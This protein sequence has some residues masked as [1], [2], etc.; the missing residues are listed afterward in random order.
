MAFNDVIPSCIINAMLEEIRKEPKQLHFDEDVFY[1]C[2]SIDI[3]NVISCNEA[4]Q[5]VKATGG[6][7]NGTISRSVDHPAFASL[8]KYLG[9]N[10]Y[11]NIETRWINGDRVMKPFYLNEVFFN[12]G[13]KFVCAAA[14][15]H[16]LKRGTVF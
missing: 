12:V 6:G 1:P 4:W 3:K 16:T 8:R 11:I 15:Q 9:Q 5:V 13:D 14:M 7:R 10:G 2:F